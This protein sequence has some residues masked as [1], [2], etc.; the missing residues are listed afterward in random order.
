MTRD[1]SDPDPSAQ[2]V[3]ILDEEWADVGVLAD[4]NIVPNPPP[5]GSG[6]GNS[7][8]GA[9]G[10]SDDQGNSTGGAGG[11]LPWPAVRLDKIALRGEECTEEHEG[12]ITVGAGK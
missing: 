5:P 7:G 2:Y 1:R 9:A 12:A 11:K 4:V 6:G 3:S 10:S 8:V